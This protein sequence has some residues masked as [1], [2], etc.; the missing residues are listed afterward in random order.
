MPGL[1]SFAVG[2]HDHAVCTF[3]IGSKTG[4]ITGGTGAFKKA[5]GTFT[6]NAITGTKLAVTVTYRT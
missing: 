5:A 1:S 6:A 3:T 4:K 2:L